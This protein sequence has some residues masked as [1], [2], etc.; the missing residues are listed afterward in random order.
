MLDLITGNNFVK[1]E[2]YDISLR[3]LNHEITVVTSDTRELVDGISEKFNAS[4]MD[5]SY[6]TEKSKLFIKNQ[7]IHLKYKYFTT[8]TCKW[9]EFLHHR[10][11]Q[12]YFSIDTLGLRYVDF[13]GDGDRSHA[14][15]CKD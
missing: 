9:N 10:G 7:L 13:Y 15:W 3:D 1:V 6:F 4:V 8:D 2:F 14:S 5:T 12:T 11:V